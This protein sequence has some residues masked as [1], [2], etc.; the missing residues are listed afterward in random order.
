MVRA[1]R[2]FINGEGDD[3]DAAGGASCATLAVGDGSNDV[4]M[5]RA[6]HIGVGIS[7]IPREHVQVPSQ[8]RPSI[9]HAYNLRKT[10]GKCR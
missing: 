8:D 7:G 2:S 4:P 6:A 1:V 5:I 10:L 3:A 9:C